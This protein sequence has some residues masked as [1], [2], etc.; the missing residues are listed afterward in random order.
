MHIDLHETTDTDETEFRPAKAAR[1]GEYIAPDSI[2]DGFYCVGDTANPQAAFQK[3]IIDS[4]RKVTH[5]APPDANGG[6]VRA[7]F[8]QHTH[9]LKA[10]WTYKALEP[11]KWFPG[12]KMCFQM[13][14]V[15]L[16]NGKIIGEGVTQDGVINYPIGDLVGLVHVAFSA[17]PHSLKAPDFKP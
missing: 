15:P 13:Q 7:E 8:S 10:P 12:F 11:I 9:G 2:P 16:R 1:D 17:D 6:A 5:I 4:V 14:L 3:A